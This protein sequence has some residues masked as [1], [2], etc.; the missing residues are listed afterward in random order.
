MSTQHESQTYLERYGSAMMGVFG[1]PGLVLARIGDTA[2]RAREIERGGETA[3]ADGIECQDR[4]DVQRVLKRFGDGDVAGR[5]VGGRDLADAHSDVRD[6]RTDRT[7]G[8]RRQFA[9][10]RAHL[11]G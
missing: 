11:V 1:E 4:R 10:Q 2:A 8:G 9:H 5:P 6:R 3:R 7:V